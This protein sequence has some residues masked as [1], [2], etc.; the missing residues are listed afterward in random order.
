MKSGQGALSRKRTVSGSTISTARTCVWNS[1]TAAPLYRSKL[2]FT[3][4]AVRGSPL[5]NLSPRRSLNS[6]VRPSGLSVHDS[7]RLGPIFWFGSGRTS[8]SWIAYSVPNGVIC[9]GALEGSN[10]VGAIVTCQAMV[11]SPVGAAW[12]DAS[13]KYPSA[14]V[15]AVRNNAMCRLNDRISTLREGIVVDRLAMMPRIVTSLDSTDGLWDVRRTR[16]LVFS[17]CLMSGRGG[18]P[19]C[20]PRPRTPLAAV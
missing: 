14:R 15:T 1:L 5:W 18:E 7:A 12:A 2:N 13:W 20:P 9:G 19:R 11:T 10:Q 3:S 6:Y 4:S 8:A 16:G 17:L